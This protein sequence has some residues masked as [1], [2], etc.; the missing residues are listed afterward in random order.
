MTTFRYRL[1]LTILII[2]YGSIVFG[3]YYAGHAAATF[4]IARECA[5]EGTFADGDHTFYCG[6][7]DDMG[8]FPASPTTTT[9]HI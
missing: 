3:A 6:D 4:S 1:T 8:P 5:L 2:A 9:P 7:H